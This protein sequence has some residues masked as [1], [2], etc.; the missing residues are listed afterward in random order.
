MLDQVVAHVLWNKSSKAHF[1]PAYLSDSFGWSCSIDSN[2]K[3]KRC[4]GWGQPSKFCGGL[5]TETFLLRCNL[6]HLQHYAATSATSAD[7]IETETAIPYNPS[8]HKFPDIGSDAF[9]HHIMYYIFSVFE[10]VPTKMRGMCGSILS[11]TRFSYLISLI[12]YITF[13][14]SPWSVRLPRL[15][16][17][18]NTEIYNKYSEILWNTF[19]IFYSIFFFFCWANPVF[20]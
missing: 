19:T 4:Q 11:K 12:W 5:Q 16:I 15:T 20:W 1:R 3:A 10:V 2:L 9:G 14:S 18:R 6:Q 17:V 8:M 13:V 7:E